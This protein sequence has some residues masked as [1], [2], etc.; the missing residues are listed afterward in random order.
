M[1]HLTRRALLHGLAA[2][3]LAPAL[4]TF[5]SSPP[6]YDLHPRQIANGTYAFVGS[7]NHFHLSNGGDI[8]NTAFVVTSEGVVVID[9]GTTYY[10]GNQIRAIIAGISGKP[11]IKTFITH[12]HPDHFLGNQSFT[13]API[14]ALPKTIAIITEEGEAL[15]E[16][17]YRILRYWMQGT[18]VAVPTE[19]IDYTSYTAGDHEFLLY[20]LQ[21]HSESDLVLFDKTTGV[22]FVQDLVFNGRTPT[23]P[24]CPR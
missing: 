10:Y 2:S 7:N 13:E 11:I 20:P 24:H 8:V 22:F 5:A 14:A 15:S 19:V 3:A 17:L 18:E 12:R 4:P 6:R 1:M 21:G 9:T 23:T 16:N